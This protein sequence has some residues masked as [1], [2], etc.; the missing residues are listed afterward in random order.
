MFRGTFPF[1]FRSMSHEIQLLNTK[2]DQNVTDQ[3][4]CAIDEAKKVTLTSART[5][6]MHNNKLMKL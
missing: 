3:Y 1:Q 6:K 2:N 4:V 5:C